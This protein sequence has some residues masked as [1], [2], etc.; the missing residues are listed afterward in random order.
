MKSI[1]TIMATALL[2]ASSTVTFA[3]ETRP[4]GLS[5]RFG[6]FMPSERL[7]KD[8]GE[9]WFGGGVEY[10]IQDLAMGENG[11]AAGQLSISLD[12]FN[13][14]DFTR[15]PLL[16]NY[17][18]R[19]EQFYFIAGA[20]VDFAEYR[21]VRGAPTKSRTEFAWQAGVGFDL[22]KGPTPVFVEAKWLGSQREVLN[23]WGVF[24]GVRF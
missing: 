8:E 13:K 11:G 15:V 23:G 10:R 17:T 4:M 9:T 24:V 14:G 21:T 2:V 7:A 16:L 18:A 20:G 5:L 19:M 3:Q 22:A 1:T 12:Y 6:A